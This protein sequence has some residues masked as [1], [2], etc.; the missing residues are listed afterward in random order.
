MSLSACSLATGGGLAGKAK[1]GLESS[2]SRRSHITEMLGPQDDALRGMETWQPP[3]P[4]SRPPSAMEK[5]RRVRSV[6]IFLSAFLIYF[7]L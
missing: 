2:R 6:D 5:E 1:S 3:E 4:L 7:L